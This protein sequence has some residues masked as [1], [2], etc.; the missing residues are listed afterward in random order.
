MKLFRK[1]KSFSVATFAEREKFRSDYRI[2]AEAILDLVPFSSALD[3]G[4]ANGFLLDPFMDAGKV[5]AGVELAPEVVQVLSSRLRAVVKVG[6]FAVATGS[7]ELVTC[8]E[9]AEHI[10][11]QR[12]RELVQTLTGLATSWI[13]FTAAPVGQTGRG[14]I[15]CRSHM[16][17]LDWFAL[18]G[19]SPDPRSLEL[20]QRLG[21]IA[22]ARWLVGN[23]TLLS[24]RG[25]GAFQPES[26]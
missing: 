4:C 5:V 16:E 2:L 14:H 12:S 8:V 25:S 17:W 6:D 18:E 19:W 9:V 3:V 13:Y 1:E 22:N 23:S 10:P 26:V 21:S 15:N 7:W 20:R 24:P 11:P